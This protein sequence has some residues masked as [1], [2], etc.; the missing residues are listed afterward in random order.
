[1]SYTKYRNPYEALDTE[2]IHTSSGNILKKASKKL[3]EI[4]NLKRRLSEG[5]LLTKE[6]T[7]KL[8]SES[9]W[10]NI[11]EPP[12]NK[13][14]TEEPKQKSASQLKKEKKR[15]TEEKRRKEYIERKREYEAEQ[16]RN[17]KAEQQRKRE[18]YDFQKIFSMNMNFTIE[19]IIYS[20]FL[21]LSKTISY[22]KAYHILS[23][24]YHP[25][26]NPQKNT[27]TEQQI[28]GNIYEY[29]SRNY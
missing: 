25:D 14:T 17:R 28:V 13:P 12:I 1:M 27:K 4:E 11:I 5:Q 29:F 22:T 19:K 8:H 15:I 10:R 9:Y 16:E 3:R 7:D 18:E 26:K 24:K 23:K 20:E 21:E 2:D 6:E